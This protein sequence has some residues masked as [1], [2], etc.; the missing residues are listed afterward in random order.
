MESGDKCLSKLCG[1]EAIDDEVY[2]GIGQGHDVHDV[3]QRHVAVL[4]ILHAIDSG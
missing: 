4:E 3:T 1:H 2:G